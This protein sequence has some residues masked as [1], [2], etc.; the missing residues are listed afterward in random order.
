MTEQPTRR[1]V[2]DLIVDL[3]DE[4]FLCDLGNWDG[5]RDVSTL[6]ALSTQE[7]IDHFEKFQIVSPERLGNIHDLIYD[8]QRQLRIRP[9]QLQEMGHSL[10]GPWISRRSNEFLEMMQERVVEAL[11]QKEAL[12][13]ILSR[14]NLEKGS[15]SSLFIPVPLDTLK[16]LLRRAGM[17]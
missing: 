12:D 6:G 5:L 7:I 10:R 16:E 11:K 3:L 14:Y 9:P 17:M 2:E 4:T 15:E 1:E 8:L 13:K